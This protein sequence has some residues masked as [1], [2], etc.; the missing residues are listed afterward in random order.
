MFEAAQQNKT[1]TW[2]E[3]AETKII[4]LDPRKGKRGFSLKQNLK[5]INK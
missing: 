2:A 5:K 3:S 4:L 1:V